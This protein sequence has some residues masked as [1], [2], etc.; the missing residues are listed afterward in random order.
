MLD[1]M[2]RVFIDNSDFVGRNEFNIVSSATGVELAATPGR[3]LLI[4]GY[5]LKIVFQ[6]ESMAEVIKKI[7]NDIVMNL[8]SIQTFV[9]ISGDQTK[10]IQQ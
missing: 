4:P 6:L 3:P 1:T 2:F 10:L 7:T 5:T 9:S 8:F